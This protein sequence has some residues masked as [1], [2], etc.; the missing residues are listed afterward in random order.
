MLADFFVR[1]ATA[2]ISNPQSFVALI[3]AIEGG[4]TE[5]ELVASIKATQIAATEAAVEADLGPRPP[6]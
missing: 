3:D 4:S 1:L 2:L 5:A 6:P